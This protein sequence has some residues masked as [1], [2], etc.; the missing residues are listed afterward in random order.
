MK[1]N[2]LFFK[3][4]LTGGFSGLS[5]AGFAGM[6]AAALPFDDLDV[7]ITENQVNFPA[8]GHR[9]GHIGKKSGEDGHLVYRPFD[10]HD[11]LI[12]LQSQP[13]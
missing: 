11:K 4:P 7:I 2:T 8:Q 9:R 10:V 5:A 13:I 12:I 6:P 1:I 3:C